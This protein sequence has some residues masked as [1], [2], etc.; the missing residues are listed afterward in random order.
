MTGTTTPSRTGRGSRM[1]RLLHHACGA[2]PSLA[3]TLMGGLLWAACMAGSATLDLWF[4]HWE[5]PGKVG[6]VAAL[7]AA[8]GALGF[9]T[10]LFLARLIDRGKRA[11]ARFAAAFL[12]LAMATIGSSAAIYV[13]VYRSY[14]ATWHADAFTVTW[15]FQWIFTAAGALAQFA[16]FGLRLYVPFGFAALTLAALWFA[17]KPR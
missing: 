12:C 17:R 9:P 2:L 11:E 14:Y 7:F 10:G 5:T 6:A 16:A 3:E 4:R 1:R 15:V 13:L 8:G